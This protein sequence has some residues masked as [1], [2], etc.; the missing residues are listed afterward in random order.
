MYTFHVMD[1][2]LW[3]HCTCMFAFYCSS[4]LAGSVSLLESL[5]DSVKSMHQLISHPTD[6]SSEGNSSVLIG[7]ISVLCRFNMISMSGRYSNRHRTYIKTYCKIW[8][9]RY[10]LF[11]GSISFLYRADIVTEIGP[12][13]ILVAKC[14]RP[15]IGPFWKPTSG[16]Y[17]FQYRFDIGSIWFLCRADIVTDIG[18]TSKRSAKFGRPDVGFMSVQYH[19]YIGPI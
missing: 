15:E 16:R 6:R 7:P 18:P 17:R 10:R 5:A 8:A 2:W 1:V 9:A 19:F 3:C 13:S 11:V 14:G 4:H 12:T